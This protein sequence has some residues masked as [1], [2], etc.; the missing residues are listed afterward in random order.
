MD[1]FKVINESL[2]TNRDIQEAKKMGL[3]TGLCLFALTV[4]VLG[5]AN[6]YQFNKKTDLIYS[7]YQDT[8]VNA[9]SEVIDQYDGCSIKDNKFICDVD[10]IAP[11]DFKVIKDTNFETFDFNAIG[12][13]EDRYI[14]AYNELVLQGNYNITYTFNS[15]LGINEQKEVAQLLMYNLLEQNGAGAIK[16]E[17]IYSFVLI[18]INIILVTSYLSYIEMRKNKKRVKRIGYF[19][20]VSLMALA[21]AVVSALVV[22]LLPITNMISMTVFT[23]LFYV[24]IFRNVKVFKK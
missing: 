7:S 18:T 2:Y 11:K 17:M 19:N 5:L 20:M 24:R 21:P 23:V 13:L 6:G 8:I 4:I 15:E 9:V 12:F 10:V 22:I 1:Y 14:V 16:N 3:F